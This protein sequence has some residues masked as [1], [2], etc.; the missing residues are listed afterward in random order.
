MK[1][2]V[3]LFA[4]FR[5]NRFSVKTFVFAGNITVEE[6]IASLDINIEDVGVTMINGRHCKLDALL[7]DGDSL[8]IFPMIGG[9]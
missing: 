3:K 1:V 7:R 5:D 8:G 6:I 9:G 4:Y 2:E